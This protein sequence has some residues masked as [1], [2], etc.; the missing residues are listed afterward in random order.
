MTSGAEATRSSDGVEALVRGLFG[1]I[2][3]NGSRNGNGHKPIGARITR[4]EIRQAEG[5]T[6]QLRIG[7]FTGPDAETKAD[8]LLRQIASEVPPSLLGYY[9]VDV[10]LEFQDAK[11]PLTWSGRHDVRR[12]DTDGTVRGHAAKFLSYVAN[13]APSQV[14]HITQGDRDRARDMLDRIGGEN[15]IKR[16]GGPTGL[17]IVPFIR[18]TMVPPRHAPVPVTRGP[19]QATPSG[20][21]SLG[22]D[23][24]IRRIRT[25]LQA[26]SGRS[27]SVHGGRGTAWGWIKVSAPPRRQDE[28]G[29]ISDADREELARLLGL[30]L[31]VHEQ[32]VSIPS[33]SDYYREYVDR[34]EGRPPS[35]H[36]KPYWD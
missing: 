11:G 23:E 4:A 8:A 18:R 2:A 31:R 22:R 14:P 10:T 9:K 5:I 17:G 32:G 15:S 1:F 3:T 6:G 28:Y 34:A 20:A 27:W 13:A 35:V 25:A 30:T 7:T 24:A 29:K 26:R 12:N 21:P 33:S 36:G 19:P 16:T